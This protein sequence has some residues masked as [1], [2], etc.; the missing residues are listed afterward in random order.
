M[1]STKT[2]CG[3]VMSLPV[4]NTLSPVMVA[5][6]TSLVH[7]YIASSSNSEILKLASTSSIIFGHQD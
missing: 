4:L 2:G 7:F 6:Q 1:T 5:C 3:N